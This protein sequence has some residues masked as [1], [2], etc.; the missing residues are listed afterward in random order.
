ML[1]DHITPLIMT[2]GNNVYV[3]WFDS[4]TIQNVDTDIYFKRSYKTTELVLIVDQLT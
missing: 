4:I 2:S 1:E 3:V